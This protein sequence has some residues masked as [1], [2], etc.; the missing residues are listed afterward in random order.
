MFKCV[1]TLLIWLILV[2]S[3]SMS[4][5]P[6][7]WVQIEAHPNEV[8][9]QK[10]AHSYGSSIND[11]SVFSIG[12]GWYA[13]AIGPLEEIEAERQL[14][15]LRAVEKIPLYSFI[16]R[17]SNYIEK[18]W[19][20]GIHDVLT[21]VEAPQN[22][23]AFKEKGDFFRSYKTDQT[24]EEAR[25]AEDVLTKTDKELL[26]IALK[27]AG[28]YSSS[29]DGSFGPKTRE[30]I[31]AWQKDNN[32][33]TTGVL[34]TVEREGLLLQH[35]RFLEPLGIEQVTDIETG[36]TI[37]LPLA[38]IEFN[39][40]SPP[41]AHFT[42]PKK[43]K[44]AAYIISQAGDEK[45]L[46]EIYE[47]LQS[48]DIIPNTSVSSLKSNRF[49]INAQNDNITTYAQAEL[50]AGNIKGFILVWPVNDDVRRLGL[51]HNMKISFEPFQGALKLD[52]E[53]RK[54]DELDLLFG[55]RIKKPK[56]VRSGVFVSADGHI[57]TE[58]IGIETCQSITIDN[59]YEARLVNKDESGRLALLQAKGQIVPTSVADIM[60]V[61]D[62]RGD[63]VLGAGYSFGGMLPS[64]SV[65]KGRIEELK[66]L[67][68]ESSFVRLSMSISPSDIG[69][70][71]LN[72]FGGLSG[73]LAFEPES[74][75]NLPDNVTHAIK[76]N[77]IIDFLNAE[78]LFLYYKVMNGPLDDFL[79]AKKARDITGLVSCWKN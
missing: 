20:K 38:I 51:L 78:G 8:E 33:P 54:Y 40:Y 7:V 49:E 35:S 12:G 29:I 3:V 16:S 21:A 26:Q 75:R 42:S 13:I 6:G 32:V 2:P 72:R 5:S 34:T 18:V 56:F 66:S 25:Y 14:F 70:P 9:A 63:T 19:P 79:L 69:G 39:K 15:N 27:S 4:R 22:S 57:V 37:N 67:D 1:I 36:V 71:I 43:T 44:H 11:V 55:L 47:G 17:G 73:L 59:G 52:L 30:A 50:R 46:A 58:A 53:D 62:R 31:T 28:F 41:L 76:P 60:Y 68:G 48:L 10:I 74:N 23:Y 64:P 65:M 61:K 77:K 45:D 24:L